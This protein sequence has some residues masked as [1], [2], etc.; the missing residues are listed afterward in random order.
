MENMQFLMPMEERQIFDAFD[1]QDHPSHI[2]EHEKL[3]ESENAKMLDEVSLNVI[4]SHIKKHYAYKYAIESGVMG[5]EQ[6]DVYGAQGGLGPMEEIGPDAGIIGPD[7]NIVQP[8]GGG[9]EY[10]DESGGVGEIEGTEPS[11]ADFA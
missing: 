9:N 3:L 8:Q 11:L 7:G 10:I 6:Q 1:Y 2:I 4:N 5:N